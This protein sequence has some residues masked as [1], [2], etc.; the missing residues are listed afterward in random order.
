MSAIAETPQ[1]PAGYACVFCGR[2]LPAVL[3]GET[4]LI[5]HDHVPHPE[6]CSF[7]EDERPQ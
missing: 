3:I 2:V 6:L 5:V 4:R 7:D 1:E